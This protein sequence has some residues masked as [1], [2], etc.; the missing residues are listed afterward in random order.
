MLQFIFYMTSDPQR[1]YDYA[2]ILVKLH[3]IE[4]A[5]DSRILILFSSRKTTVDS[6]YHVS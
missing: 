2:V 4:T 3:K 1:V 6:L 5:E